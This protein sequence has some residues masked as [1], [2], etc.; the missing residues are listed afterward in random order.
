MRINLISIGNSRGVRIPASVIREC[1]LDNELE[2]RVEDGSIILEPVK[3]VREGW[4][5]AFREMAARGDDAAAMPEST[6]TAFDEDEWT[7]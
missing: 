1:G 2:M 5:E 3:P 4:D 7:W 6:D